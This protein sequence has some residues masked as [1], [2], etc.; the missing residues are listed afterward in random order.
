MAT[1][2]RASPEATPAHVQPRRAVAAAAFGNAMKWYDFSVY[3]FFASYIAHN[4]FRDDDPTSALMSTFVVFGAG[5]VARP[6]GAV[7]GGVYG[8]RMGRKAALMLSIGAMGIGTLIIAA[9]PPIAFIGVG[10]PILL[11]AGRLFQGFSTGGEIGG[12][13][14][15]MLE[16]AP[17]DRRSLYSSWLQASMGISNLLSALVGFTITTVFPEEAV[18]DWA[19]RIPFLLGLLI[20][21]IGLYIRRSLPESEEFTRHSAADA[22]RPK[23]GPLRG[24]VTEYPKEL[25]AAFLFSILW[26]V[27]VYAFLIYL[28]TYYKDPAIGLGFSSQQAFLASLFGNAVVIV[29]CLAGGWIADRVGAR[30]VVV[31]SSV[32][33]VLIPTPCLWWLHSQPN[34]TVL[35]LVHAVLCASVAAF[36]GV[37]PSVLPRVFPVA[38]RSTGLAVSYNLAAVFF[39]GT[40]PA[41]MTWATA[42]LTVYAPTLWV[43][44]GCLCCLASVPALFRQVDHVTRQEAEEYRKAAVT[45]PA[46]PPAVER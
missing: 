4:F 2:Q 33:M 17:A 42:R 44:I 38:V 7:I 3:A 32:A 11:L 18:Q 31:W 26:T 30:Q 29:G 41:L 9:A 37:A 22:I 1:S 19:W 24:L 36:S 8:D 28:P 35:L 34:L 39:A 20:I 14:A 45:G 23:P 6:L 46:Q 16:N 25:C 12:A 43:I 40:T 27:C 5:F 13:A 10:A 15:Y 21:P